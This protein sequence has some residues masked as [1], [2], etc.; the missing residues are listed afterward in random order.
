MY[1][2]TWVASGLIAMGLY[3]GTTN[4]MTDLTTAIA[5]NPTTRSIGGDAETT[6]QLIKIYD[7]DGLDAHLLREG[8]KVMRQTLAAGRTSTR[9]DDLAIA[10]NTMVWIG[11][12]VNHATITK[13]GDDDTIAVHRKIRKLMARSREEVRSLKEHKRALQGIMIEVKSVTKEECASDITTVRLP[14]NPG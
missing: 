6:S 4:A 14:Q 1:K 12:M 10:E 7:A 9:A 11:C 5:S 3:A 2:N 8:V 13:Q